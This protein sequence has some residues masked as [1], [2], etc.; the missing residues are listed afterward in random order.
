MDLPDPLLLLIS[1]VHRSWEV[2]KATSYI[3]SE[4]LYISSSQSSS[5]CSSIC[6]VRVHVVHPYSSI[7]TTAAWK[8]LCFILSVRS[9]FHMT[10]SLLIAVHVFASWCLSQLMRHCF[11]GR[12]TCPLVSENYHLVWRCCLFD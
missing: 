12:W 10:D 6:L 4:L 8:K 7:V 2:F 9:D 11:Q 3:C 1:V 5:L